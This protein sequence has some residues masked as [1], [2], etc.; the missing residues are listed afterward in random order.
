MTR[1]RV[2]FWNSDNKTYVSDEYNG[3]KTELEQFGSSDSC[4]KTWPEILELL[5]GVTTLVDFMKAISQINRCYHS[6]LPGVELIGTRLNVSH[7]LEE[8]YALVDGLDEVYSIKSGVP[9]VELVE[10]PNI[11]GGV[12]P[13]QLWN[14]RLV[15]DEDTFSYTEA[16]PGDY[17]TQGVVDDAID[18]VPEA[19]FCNECAQMGEPKSSRFDERTGKWRN[20]YHTF[21]KVG[22]KWP[23]CVWEYCGDCFYGETEMR[24]KPMQVVAG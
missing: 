14:G 18:C 17:V 15:L 16:K 5:N 12:K 13:A 4:D 20:T 24:G 10:H 9:G 3:D 7:N 19:C 2:I 8:L 22:G 6:C 11:P 21:R 23:D 1:R